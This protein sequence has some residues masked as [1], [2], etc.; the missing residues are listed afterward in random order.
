[1][2]VVVI[3]AY[4]GNWPNEY[5]DLFLKGLENN[6]MIDYLFIT[7]NE[8]P[9]INGNQL[10]KIHLT[11]EE[12]K[13][14]VNN[15]VDF[16]VKLNNV[17]KLCDLKPL[18]GFLFE[19]YI[20]E[21]QFWAY[22]DIDILLGD[23]DT[24]LPNLLNNYDIIT[25][26]PYWISGPFTIFKNN[27]FCNK[28]FLKSKHISEILSN[29]KYLGFDECGKKYEKLAI[30]LSI[31]NFKECSDISDDIECM[32]FLITMESHLENLKFYQD[33][34]IKE[35]ILINESI[36]YL[37]GKLYFE[38]KELFIYH[39]ITEKQY[40]RFSFPKWKFIPN[41]F[42]ILHTG[43]YDH[44]T[45]KWIVSLNYFYRIS[46]NEIYRFFMRMFLSFN[47]RLFKKKIKPKYKIDV[48]R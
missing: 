19:D 15:K 13:N 16:K 38:K 21:Y 34:K 42:Q 8:L 31:L 40:F 3:I 7:D 36:N 47:F 35:S 11:L 43:M 44:K 2:K 6:Q 29:E 17:R 30:G 10:K 23:L 46:R 28:L 1:M 26:H 32:T 24:N 12:L 25:F 18:Y 48:F 14:F 45:Y 20:R 9:N 33:S 27:D 5:L 22:G 4:Y 37:F 41:E 39:F